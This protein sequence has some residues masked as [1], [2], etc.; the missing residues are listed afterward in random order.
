MWGQVGVQDEYLITDSQSKLQSLL[1]IAAFYG[2]MYRVT[3]G[4]AKTKVTVVGSAAD[5]QYYGDVSPWQ[6][7]GQ[8]VTVAVDNDHLGQVVSGLAQEQKNLDLRIEKGRN[9]LFGLLGPGFSFKCLLSPAVKLHLF[10]T[11]TCPILRSGLSSLSLRTQMLEP[12]II[13]QRKM[14]RGILNFSKSSNIPALH[15]LLGE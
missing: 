6:M 11:Y 4:A 5:M 13:C 3:Y 7:D 1:D 14:L 8:T 10:R 9:N 15:F 12:L 2:K